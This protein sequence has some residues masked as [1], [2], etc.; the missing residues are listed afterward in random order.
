MGTQTGHGKVDCSIAIYEPRHSSVIENKVHSKTVRLISS[1][2]R[3][4]SCSAG[5]AWGSPARAC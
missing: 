5:P 1:C 4:S 2:P 3:W